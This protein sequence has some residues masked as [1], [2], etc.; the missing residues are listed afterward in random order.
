MVLTLIACVCTLI[1]T[2]IT[3]VVTVG[4]PLIENT[5]SMTKLTVAVENLAKQFEISENN[6]KDAHKRLHVRID[7]AE[8]D[9]KD[10]ENRITKLEARK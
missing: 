8:K 9:L 1:G 5:K 3:I 6:N 7:E 2:L 4:R 10:H